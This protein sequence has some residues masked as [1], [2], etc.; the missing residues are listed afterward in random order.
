MKKE[1]PYVLHKVSPNIQSIFYI[2]L[3]KDKRVCALFVNV[4]V[5]NIGS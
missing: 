3:K 4:E 2:T 1:L 5:T